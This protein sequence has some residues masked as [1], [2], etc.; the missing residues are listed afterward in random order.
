MSSSQSEERIMVFTREKNN[1]SNQNRERCFLTCEKRFSPFLA[2][3]SAAFHTFN[4]KSFS[5][6][7][8]SLKKWK[9]FWSGIVSFVSLSI[10][11]TVESWWNNS[12]KG[13]TERDASLCC[14]FCRS[15]FVF[16][17]SISLYSNRPFY[18][19]SVHKNLLEG[20]GLMRNYLLSKKFGGPLLAA[21][22]I[23]REPLSVYLKFETPPTY[24]SVLISSMS[25]LPAETAVF[26]GYVSVNVYIMDSKKCFL[27]FPA[28]SNTYSQSLL[29]LRKSYWMSLDVFY[30]LKSNEMRC[31]KRDTLYFVWH[32]WETYHYYFLKRVF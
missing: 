10:K 15:Y 14:A 18:L 17:L 24:L 9:T 7:V 11:K 29:L 30:L 32:D 28:V 1:T 3:C 23:F 19:G 13:K 31:Y 20:G 27:T 26:A 8:F 5:R 6:R 22:N 21:V 2:A 16:H 4:E 25:L 12:A